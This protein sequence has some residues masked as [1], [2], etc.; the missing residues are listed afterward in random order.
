MTHRILTL[1]A[2]AILAC[3]TQAQPDATPQKFPD[4]PKG[5]D[6]SRAGIDRGDQRTVEYDST[7]VGI[8]RKAMVYTPPNYTKDKKYPVLYLLH[9]IGGDEKEWVRGGAPDVIL[10]NLITDKKAV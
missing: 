9:G 6:T 7:T 1:I 3:P 5:F 8:T 10:D 2:C 4:P